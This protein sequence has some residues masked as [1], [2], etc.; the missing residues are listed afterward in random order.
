MFTRVGPA[1]ASASMWA[2][3]VSLIAASV[4][5]LWSLGAPLRAAPESVLL[6]HDVQY[7]VMNA[8]PKVS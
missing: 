8:L 7:A 3:G 4:S 6:W 5:K 2:A 1:A